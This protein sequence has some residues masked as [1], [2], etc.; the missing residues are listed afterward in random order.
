MRM[1]AIGLTA[2]GAALGLASAAGASP[3]SAAQPLPIVSTIAQARDVPFAG[4]IQL[5]VDASRTGQGIFAVHEEFPVAAGPLTLLYPRWKPGNHAPSGEVDK[6]AGLVLRADGKIVPWTRDPVDLFAFHLNVP[7]GTR[8][9]TADFQY[10]SR[11]GD[12]PG[13]VV[14]TPV[15][16]NVE[17]TS[18]LLYPAGYFVRQI[19]VAASV[20][21]PAGWTAATALRG[22]RA[23]DTE[24][25]QA[26]PMDV[27]VDSPAFAG[28]YA[29]I[30]A[31]RSG[32]TLNI[33]ADHQADLDAATPAMI[34][35]YRRLIDQADKLYGA[36]HYDHYDFLFALSDRLSGQGLEH[37]RSSQ[38]IV[39][40]DFFR[41]WVKKSAD[42]SLLPHEYNHSWNGKFRRPADL[43]APDYRTPVRG[44]LLWVYEGQTEYWGAVFAA[45]AGLV[46]RDEALGELAN[47]AARFTAGRP[48]REWRSL[49]DSTNQPAFAR[50][51]TLDWASWQRGT[52]YYGEGELLWL[53]ADQLIRERSHGA[54]SLDQFARRFF[55]VRPG[56]M[57]ELTYT[58]DDIVA[59]LNAV[60]PYAWREWLRS[61]LDTA[62]D[63]RITEALGRGGYRLVWRD[64]PSLYDKDAAAG[65]KV[66]DF[67]YSL[68]FTLG[69]EGKLSGVL[70]NGPAFQAG[71]AP[72]QTLVAVNGTKVDGGT[73]STALTAAQWT[74]APINLLVKDGDSFRTVAIDYHA[75]PRF[76]AL[77]RI[78]TAPAGIDRMFEPLK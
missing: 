63:Q 77:E 62:D 68:G 39:G 25:Y 40:A 71:L 4:T 32:V 55:G 18:L 66:S 59:E 74:T 47:L 67:T 52:D 13:S 1:T 26:E 58:F 61:W 16:V 12:A 28:K 29:R 42:R 37:H 8:T 44:S 9:L 49:Q 6:L 23:G 21:Y 46:S 38:N 78:G 50:A 64:K 2:L 54:R 31:L 20:R 60:E 5:A 22:S 30:E 14:M 7:D 75:G 27:L 17:W 72:G 24:T 35:G 57:G 36:R 56:D 65:A 3:N 33:F 73:L 43:W 34:D 51:K 48:G 41:E 11:V 53:A 76:P 19:P 69:G 45:R 10:L 70:W 15:V